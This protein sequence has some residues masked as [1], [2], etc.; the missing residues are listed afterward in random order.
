MIYY[1]GEKYTLKQMEV[2][3]KNDALQSVSLFMPVSD[4][5]VTEGYWDLQKWIINE[6]G[7]YLN[8]ARFFMQSYGA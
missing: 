2:L 7:R 6:K 1:E 4:I 8:H 5:E 3:D